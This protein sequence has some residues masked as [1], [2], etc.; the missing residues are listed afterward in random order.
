RAGWRGHLL[1]GRADPARRLCGRGGAGARTQHADP[2]RRKFLAAFRHARRARPGGAGLRHARSR[3]HRRR[4][5]LARGRR[6][7]R[8]AWRADVIAPVSGSERASAG[9]HADLP[10]SRI[11]RLGGRVGATAARARRR[12]RRRA[13]ASRQ[14]HGLG[15]GRCRALPRRLR[16]KDSATRN[17]LSATLYKV[18][19]AT[20]QSFSLNSLT[21]LSRPILRRASSPISAWSNHWAPSSTA[22][23]G[24]STENSTRSTPISAT[25]FIIAGVLKLPE[26]VR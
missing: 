4:Q 10:L 6:T 7:R 15:R 25:A 12:V 13:R 8:G 14:R 2:D 3:T 17:A 16:R 9:R 20:G 5:R 24:Q 11:R 19:L 22:S 26:V 1:A 18:R 23:K 21:A